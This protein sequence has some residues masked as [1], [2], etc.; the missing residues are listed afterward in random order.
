MG[1]VSKSG[2][3]LGDD[4]VCPRTGERYALKGGKLQPL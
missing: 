4:L 3:R 1:W 2:E